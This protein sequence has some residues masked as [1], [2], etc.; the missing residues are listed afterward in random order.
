ML[1]LGQL[2]LQAHGPIDELVEAIKACLDD[3]NRVVG[4]YEEEFDQR[5]NDHN[6][7][8]RQ[9]DDLIRK[10]NSEIAN[11]QELIN[12]FLQPQVD[13]LTEDIAHLDKHIDDTQTEIAEETA[14]REQAHNDYLAR[15]QEHQAG[16]DAINEAFALLEQITE[17]DSDLSL[18]QLNS[19]R[20]SIEKVQK[21]LRSKRTTENVFVQALLE[22]ST[23]KF[24]GAEALKNVEN[25]LLQVRENLS[26][27]LDKEAALDQDAENQ[28]EIEVKQLQQ[29]ITES[30]SQLVEK[31]GQLANTQEQI[32]DGNEFIEER[33]ADLAGYNTDLNAE[34]ESFDIATT[35]FN[36]MIAELTS[37]IDYGNQ[38]LDIIEN[39]TLEDYIKARV[40]NKA[41]VI[42][43]PSGQRFGLNSNSD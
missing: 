22:L 24:A 41:G 1:G 18:V 2:H 25:L 16:I 27:D 8:V 36:E 32:Q 28:F 20:R 26:S 13:Q 12:N 9:L 14:E 38:A 11:T 10:A 37:E 15:A 6:T 3:L 17:D 30:T 33:Q 5:T 34:N 19:A 21:N 29:D 4:E 39:L 42:D 35:H 23:E 40:D 43:Q 31:Q 7:A